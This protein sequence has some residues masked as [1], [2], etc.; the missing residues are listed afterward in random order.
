MSSHRIPLSAIIHENFSIVMTYAFSQPALS[1]ML[2]KCFI[3]EWKYLCK[4]CFETS[5][6]RANRALIEIAILLRLLDDKERL[7]EYFKAVKKEP[8]GKFITQNDTE[9]PLFIRD[10]TNKIVHS[11]G[12]KWNFSD[13]D[14]PIVICLCNDI[15][16]EWKRAEIS[17]ID[18]AYYCGGFMA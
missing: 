4:A 7:N 15:K 18:F 13:P 14:N 3:G 5:E 12:L 10:M 17:M 2:Q 9:K 11:S 6:T 16:S 1:K 8:I